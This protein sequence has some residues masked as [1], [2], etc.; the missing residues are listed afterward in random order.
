MIYANSYEE[1][2]SWGEAL[3]RRRT[4]M[5]MSQTALASEVGLAPNTI[6]SY[7]C[8]GNGVS[9]LVALNIADALDWDVY[10]WGVDA[11]EILA[12]N[13]WRRAGRRGKM[14]HSDDYDS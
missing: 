8:V 14:E 10:Q 4:K 11:D 6:S 3:R 7:E 1:R 5:R 9:L 2:R 12:D 13:S